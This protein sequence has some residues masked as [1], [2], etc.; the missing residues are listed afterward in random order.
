MNH[1]MI[2][3]VG[4]AAW[5]K[6][7]ISALFFLGLAITASTSITHPSFPRETKTLA[8]APMLV[9]VVEVPTKLDRTMAALDPADARRYR[10]AFAA[11]RVGAWAKADA[12]LAA[13]IDTRLMGHVLA[14]RYERRPAMQEELTTW[15]KAYADLPDADLLYAQA[16]TK[17]HAP[18]PETPNLWSAGYVPDSAADFVTSLA[19]H[20]AEPPTATDLLA[21][22]IDSALQNHNPI[23]A[24]DLLIAAQ[25]EATL[26][27]TF[28][29]DA[30]AAIAAG[31]F[32]TG[33][34][35]QASVLAESAAIAHQPLGLW[36]QGLIA[37]EKGNRA[38]ASAS[39]SSL[40]DHPALNPT[41]RAAASFWASRALGKEGF[42]VES[43][44]RLEQ[45]ARA[46]NSFY[47]M[48]AAQ[49]LGRSP[50]PDLSRQKEA[51]LW[52]AKQRDVLSK[53][54]EGWRA[55][56]LI[57]IGETARAESELRRL[58]PQGRTDLQQAMLSLVN[59]VPMPALAL[60]LTS[61]SNPSGFNGAAYPLPPWKP[62]Q[63]F[64][65]D[66]ALLFAL[67][68][69]ESGF[70]PEAISSRGAIGLMQIMPATAKAFSSNETEALFD[71]SI[72]LSMGQDYVSDL[73]HRPHIG[74][75]LLLLL[76]SYNSGPNNV[77]RWQQDE[78]PLLFMETI[79]VRETRHY[80]ARV[81]P[82]YW[83]Y[84]VRLN[85][86]LT[87]LKQLADGK[88]PRAETL[89]PAE[90]KLAEEE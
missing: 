57:Q 67:A 76:A 10:T 23:V 40:A 32:Y 65:V 63:G 39:F 66:R 88:W 55:I 9:P 54:Q 73:V 62:A 8:P 48:L 60:A 29:A 35:E 19:S 42:V 2:S 90:V 56:A 31:F 47:G 72:N 71:P 74:N 4:P 34:R 15:L 12:A 50:I 24:R 81:L 44:H 22:K 16:G 68:R 77:A 79:P 80:V 70:D 14:D 86:S 53:F 17:A 59:E 11:Q 5:A 45:A 89:E 28:A 1:L 43:K 61:F 83:A 46:S 18:K 64:R 20:H 52:N 21:Q 7:S 49:K 51:T 75:N 78:D 69:H 36:I 27:G 6:L 87:T 30:Q 26:S 85:E 33:E 13:L 82:Y 58:N 25:N 37:W 41:N 38:A 84:R 3:R